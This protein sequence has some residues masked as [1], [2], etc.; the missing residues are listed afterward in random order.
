MALSYTGLEREL[1][2]WEMGWDS[3]DCVRS[4]MGEIWRKTAMILRCSVPAR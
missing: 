3:T 1:W 2:Y 4:Y